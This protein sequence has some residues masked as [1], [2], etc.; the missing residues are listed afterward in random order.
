MQNVLK[1]YCLSYNF[2]MTIDDGN[3]QIGHCNKYFKQKVKFYFNILCCSPEL[4]FY[5]T[6]RYFDFKYSFVFN[7]ST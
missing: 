6:I 2:T 5:M 3:D 4:Y 7:E 1:H